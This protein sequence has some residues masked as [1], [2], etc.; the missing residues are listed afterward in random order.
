MLGEKF[1]TWLAN[2]IPNATFLKLE[3]YVIILE[4]L[5]DEPSRFI[6]F[7]DNGMEELN[8]VLLN[9]DNTSAILNNINKQLPDLP[10]LKAQ[11]AKKKETK[12][13]DTN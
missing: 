12:A 3:M 13:P 7:S 6:E 2:F 1:K 4:Y 8:R 5:Q 10:D 9:V 11:D